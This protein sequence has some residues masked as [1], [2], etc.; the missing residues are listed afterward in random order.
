MV[1]TLEA[2]TVGGQY[3][4]SEAEVRWKGSDGTAWMPRPNNCTSFAERRVSGVS[5]RGTAAPL[6]D[7]QSLNRGPD[8]LILLTSTLILPYE[9]FPSSPSQP[10]LPRLHV[11][12]WLEF[13]LL[14][15]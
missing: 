5:A 14:C 8:G 9:H 1:M 12:I 2:R 4:D 13:F 15:N 7:Q 3:E 11:V 6:T 10:S